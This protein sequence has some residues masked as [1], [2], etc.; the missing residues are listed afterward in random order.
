MRLLDEMTSCQAQPEA[1]T[2]PHDYSQRGPVDGLTERQQS[3]ARLVMRGRTDNE[4]AGELS[5]SP[6]R[7]KQLVAIVARKLPGH[8]THRQRI[9]E[10]LAT[11]P[12]G[13]AA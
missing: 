7:V 3:V 9:R 5:I 11:L 2:I 10:Y 12:T 13:L 6:Q 4:I 8:G 1:S